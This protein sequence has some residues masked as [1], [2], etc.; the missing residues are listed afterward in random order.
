MWQK[1]QRIHKREMFIPSS[2]S[3]TLCVCMH[4]IHDNNKISFCLLSSCFSSYFIRCHEII[5]RYLCSKHW[6]QQKLLLSK[7]WS[8]I[9]KENSLSNLVDR[10]PWLHNNINLGIYKRMKD[11]QLIKLIW[12]ENWCSK[13]GVLHPIWYVS[14]SDYIS[15]LNKKSSFFRITYNTLIFVISEGDFDKCGTQ[16]K[17]YT[18]QIHLVLDA[19]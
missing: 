9:I 13:R 7:C 16:M 11:H 19:N 5:M 15:Y 1:R 14:V 4:R 10:M 12:T 17:M 6:R 3:L 2:L 18:I 8:K